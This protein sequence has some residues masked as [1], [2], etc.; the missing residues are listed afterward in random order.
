MLRALVLDSRA[1]VMAFRQVG[2]AS[3]NGRGVKK[4]KSKHLSEAEG[5]G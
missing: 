3:F 4:L 1:P 2:F 5:L